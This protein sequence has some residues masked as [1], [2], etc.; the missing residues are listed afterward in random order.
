MQKTTESIILR[1]TANQEGILTSDF[2]T[3][4]IFRGRCYGVI[5]TKTIAASTTEYFVFMCADAHNVVTLPPIFSSTGG[6][7][8]VTIYA[9]TDYTGVNTL[10]VRNKNV[11]LSAD[12]KPFARLFDTGTGSIKGEKAMKFLI[13]AAHKE[14][15]SVSTSLPSVLN[16]FNYLIEVE[17]TDTSEIIFAYEFTWFEG[18]GKV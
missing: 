6:P 13:T 16:G 11:P 15:G 2:A 4:F 5:D 17:N 7:V 10:N 12:N 1:S 14:S 9:G 3:D 18:R 8:N